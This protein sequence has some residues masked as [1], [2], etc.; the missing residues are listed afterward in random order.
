MIG[1]LT[2][3]SQAARSLEQN[4]DLTWWSCAAA[5]IL[6]ALFLPNS[7]E[8]IDAA[9]SPRLDRL[10]PRRKSAVAG[11]VVGA[12]IVIAILA[13]LISQSRDVTEFIYFNF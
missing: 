6:V 3:H 9:F 12:S 13:V 2:T 10:K 11:V 5:A 8:I 1:A 4:F 7:Q